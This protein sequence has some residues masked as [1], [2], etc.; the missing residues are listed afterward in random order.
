MDLK[1]NQCHSTPVLTFFSGMSILKVKLVYTAVAGVLPFL[2]LSHIDHKDTKDLKT[3]A[4]FP[5]STHRKV[6][7]WLVG[8]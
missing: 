6:T 3:V 8:L 7:D 1:E 2:Y 5:S 4:I